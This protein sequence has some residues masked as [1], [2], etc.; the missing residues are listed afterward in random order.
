[1]SKASQA[2]MEELHGQLAKSLA[3]AVKDG[4]TVMD[5]EGNPLKMDCPAA[6]LSV[7]RQFLKD[8]H[9]EGGFGNADLS[10]LEKAMG[11]MNDMPL[12]GEV[13]KEYQ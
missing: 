12:P 3:E 9:I 1:M 8:N 13:P 4:V 2:L 10:D 6:V 7:A 5:K 11:E